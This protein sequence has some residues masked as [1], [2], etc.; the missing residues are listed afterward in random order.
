[1]TRT[2]FLADGVPVRLLSTLLLSAAACASACAAKSTPKPPPSFVPVYETNFPDPFVMQAGGRYL[3]YATNAE[4]FQA[5]VQMAVSNDLVR[6]AP[7]RSADGKLHDAMPVLPAWAEKGWTWAPEV[8]KL[9]EHYLL[10]FTARERA[11]QRQCTGVA[12]SRDPLGPFVSSAPEPLVCQRELGGTIDASPF[13]DAD[14]QLY[15]YYKADANAV[16]KPTE[17][18]VQRMTADGLALT[19]APVALLR[20]DQPWEAHVIESPTMVRHGGDYRLFYSANHFG[21][22]PNQRLSPYAMGY[23]RCA[24]PMGPCTDAADNPILHSYTDRTAGCL[25]GPGHQAVFEADGRSFIVFHAH[26][27]TR[28]C[29]NAGKGRYMYIAPLFWEDGEPRIAPSLRAAGK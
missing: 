16:R 11:S 28:A 19:G 6:W 12:E 21:W 3:A 4:R 9:G 15:L 17:I 26:A 18:F 7:L 13:R 24:G 14:G 23:A 20:N 5:N 8:L 22:E 10:F 1:M 25:S 27:A 2:S 29:G